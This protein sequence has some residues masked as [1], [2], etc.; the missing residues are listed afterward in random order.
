MKPVH[1]L[2]EP[3]FC[4][5]SAALFPDF[6]INS[7]R[8][9]SRVMSRMIIY[10]GL[11]LPA[12]SSDPPES[13]PGRLLRFLF[14]LASD[15]VY[16]CPARCRAGGSLLRCLS[17]LTPGFRKTEPWGGLFLLHWPWSCLH[18][19]LSGILPCEA[20]TFLTCQK[21]L[22]SFVLLESIPCRGQILRH[23]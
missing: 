14:G 17:T 4:N 23:N 21:Q 8:T 20:R 3:V 6:P 10:L 1:I 16:M 18:R 7:S 12:A 2:Y 19:K 11:L 15:G 9:I 13:S 22:R 5:M